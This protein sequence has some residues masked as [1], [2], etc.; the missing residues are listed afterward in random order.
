[1][2]F[3]T[4][5]R[6]LGKK[7]YVNQYDPPLKAVAPF[8]EA[9]HEVRVTLRPSEDPGDLDMQKMYFHGIREGDMERDGLKKEWGLQ[10]TVVQ[11]DEQEKCEVES[12]SSTRIREASKAGAIELVESMCTPSVAKAILGRSIYDSQC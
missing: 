10:I 4:I 2:G 8:F 5:T 6:F 3:D 11:P 1:M 7:Y 9:G 12:I